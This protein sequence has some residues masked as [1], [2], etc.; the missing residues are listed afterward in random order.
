[1]LSRVIFDALAASRS[2]QSFASRYGLRSKNGFA[3]QFVAGATVA[4]AV[5][6]AKQIEA[7]GMTQTLD[8]LGPSVA[9]LGEADAAA[10][11]FIGIINEIGA[12]GIGRN[13]SVKL[14]ALGLRV[15]RATCVDNLRRVLDPAGAQDFFVRIDMEDSRHTQVTLD[16]FET[17]W[18]QG[19]RNA[20][21]V[22]Q[23]RLR[24]SLEDV[25][26]LN[27]LGARIRLV[28]G[29]YTESKQVA[30][31]SRAQVDRAFITIMERLLTEGAY[32][33]IATHD[34]A[35]VEATKQFARAHGV[36]PDRY[37]FQML[38]GVR[39]DLQTNLT[40]QG[41]RVRICVP[42]GREW[43]SYLM[44]RLGERPLDVRRIVRSFLLDR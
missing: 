40:A 4:D 31:R 35:L 44:R 22:V 17:L 37:E 25:R 6:A 1:M 28:K 14:T 24:R 32:P 33:A 5:D 21:V 18:Q 30:Y 38:Y 42:F 36:L 19:Y 12:A 2:M 10:R 27:V 23:A 15:D 11:A 7:T 16:I 9:T 20:G 3:R 43:F 26:R 34:E 8:Y 29:E 13:V 41:Y 39:P